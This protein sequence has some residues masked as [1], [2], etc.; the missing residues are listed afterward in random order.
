MH[1]PD[2]DPQQEQAA[3][4]AA[5]AAAVP[6]E[7]RQTLLRRLMDTIPTTREGVWSYPIQW[8]S[9]NKSTMGAKFTQVWEWGVQCV[10]VM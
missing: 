9:Y 6:A 4:A 8:D 7:D 1:E 10:N 2:P 5:A 3:A